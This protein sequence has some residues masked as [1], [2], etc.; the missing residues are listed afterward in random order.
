MNKKIFYLIGLS[1]LVLLP[2]ITFAQ[3][4]MIT[5]L[6]CTFAKNLWQAAVAGGIIAWSVVVILFVT[7]I[8]NPERVN[9]AK[10]GLV[11]VIIGTV[12]VILGTSSLTMVGNAI[13]LARG[14]GDVCKG[15][16]G[17]GEP[18]PCGKCGAGETCL[19]KTCVPSNQ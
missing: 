15:I 1:A 14:E 7:S 6:L 2:S 19:N 18:D 8:G 11:V 16:G 4:D 5:P 13:G 12:I 9:I 10:K 17:T 3:G